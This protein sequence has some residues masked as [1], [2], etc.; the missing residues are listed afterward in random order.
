M[1]YLR[2]FSTPGQP[3]CRASI[4]GAKL[5]HLSPRQPGTEQGRASM[6][7]VSHILKARD[8]YRNKEYTLKPKA[9]QTDRMGEGS[10]VR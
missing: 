8:Q 9:I 1:D 7:K 3:A 10:G 2:P 4:D 5:S 6:A